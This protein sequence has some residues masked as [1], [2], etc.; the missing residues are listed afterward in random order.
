VQN[1]R[2]FMSKIRPGHDLAL[3]RVLNDV[4]ERRLGTHPD[5][6]FAQLDMLHFASLTIFH[7]DKLGDDLI[8]ECAFDGGESEFLDALVGAGNR[9]LDKIYEHC[10]GFV[11][12]SGAHL[13]KQFL[14]DAIHKPN[15]FHIGNPGRKVR[16]INSEKKLRETIDD[17]LDKHRHGPTDAAG[18]LAIVRTAV[19]APKSTATD[20]FPTEQGSVFRW[21]RDP[22]NKNYPL[23]AWQGLFVFVG[24]LGFAVTYAV[25]KLPLIG[26]PVSNWIES[27]LGQPLTLSPRSDLGTTRLE[28][29]VARGKLV[30]GIFGLLT[31]AAFGLVFP[32]KP[33]EEK[34]RDPVNLDK[35]QSLLEQEDQIGYVQ[36]HLA[37]VVSLRRGWY[38]R[39]K[40]RVTFAVLNQ[41]YR[42]FFTRG[43]LAGVPGIHFGHW[44]ILDDGRLLFLSNYD[45]SWDNYLDDFYE[46]MREG[47][48]VLWGQ[49]ETFPGV[50]PKGGA[51][52]KAW[53]RMQQTSELVWYSAYPDLTVDSIDNNSRIRRGLFAAPGDEQTWMLR[54]GRAQ[55]EE[56]PS[57][58]ARHQQTRALLGE[59]E[60]I[61]SRDIQGLLLSGYD[62]LPHACYVFLRIRNE[63]AARK[64]LTTL[65]SSGAITSAEGKQEDS[66]INI[67]FTHKGVQ[68]LGGDR[69]P[70]GT[71]QRPFEEGMV[72]GHRSRVLGDIN[73]KQELH[74]LEHPDVH[75]L[76]DGP[77]NE[78]S[79]WRWGGPTTEAIH[80]VAMFFARDQNRLR[81]LEQHWLAPDVTLGAFAN[82]GTPDVVYGT[83]PED[84]REHFGFRDGIS[85]PILAYKDERPEKIRKMAALKGSHADDM[86]RPGEFIFGY[87]DES[88]DTAFGPR[89]CKGW[90]F[91][92]NGS[93]L[94]VRQ[95]SQDVDAFNK[96]VDAQ[97]RQ[98]HDD[99]V[100]PEQRDA[101]A[102]RFIGRWPDGRPLVSG[103]KHEN[104]FNFD[105]TGDR[106]GF[107]C[108]IGAHI[109]RA[110]PRDG[111]TNRHRI[112]RRGRMYDDGGE[113]GLLFMCLNADLE[114]QFEFI[115]QRW[116]NQPAFGGLY[117]ETDP[118]IGQQPFPKSRA[119][120]QN[121]LLRQRVCDVPQFVGVKGGGY[122]FLPGINA[123]KYLARD[124]LMD[125]SA[126]A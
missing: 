65:V 115:Q 107:S 45:G 39:L 3:R 22:E 77:G 99:E 52:F 104:D 46:R 108:P 63:D 37:S 123:L 86:L 2:F 8:F 33:K 69:L 88:G 92:R 23:V 78:P 100:T 71:F 76:A 6:P 35:I 97:A 84:R 93:Y 81:C 124:P 27:S 4:G 83:I 49:A 25:T 120:F 122:F 87:A 110:N 9:G 31:V 118:L 47:I 103:G 61:D 26:N 96:C 20:L 74:A 24:I 48:G 121:A 19:N 43:A 105:K 119:T 15:L 38:P 41:V 95:L 64:W 85:Q 68:V 40:L 70:P 106:E 28:K 12:G 90:D 73:L 75:G 113:R 98:L 54:F 80:L 111:R 114:R 57:R 42:A 112:L 117:K 5:L 56:S 18:F 59:P 67:A 58:K 1:I 79:N 17:V 62:H 51:V 53:A 13:M 72:S 29:M 21:D 34:D 11:P 10:N 30:A 126:S 66:S 36:N 102:A 109:R 94:V 116:V 82:I 50:P 91:G 16:H 44:T 60:A 14:K 101:M 125:S 7:D 89:D 55:A 32:A